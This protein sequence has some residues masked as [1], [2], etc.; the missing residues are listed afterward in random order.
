MCSLLL[1]GCGLRAGICVVQL[2][3]THKENYRRIAPIRGKPTK[4]LVQ[5]GG[6]FMVMIDFLKKISNY[7]FI[8]CTRYS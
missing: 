8:Q 5:T 7:Y 6:F 4:S 3:N 2:L 1:K